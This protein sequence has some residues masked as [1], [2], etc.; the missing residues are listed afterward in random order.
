M[1][2][3]VQLLASIQPTG[4][5]PAYATWNVIPASYALTNGNRTAN[6]SGAASGVARSSTAFSGKQYHENT[7]TPAANGVGPGVCNAAQNTGASYLGQTSDGMGYYLPGAD[8]YRTG[9]VLFNGASDTTT[10]ATVGMATDATA[11]DLKVWIRRA[12]GGGWE[13]G[14][15]PTTGSTPTLTLPTGTYYA[16]C[17]CQTGT[18]MTI[19][20]GQAAFVMW[21]PSGGY[22]GY[23]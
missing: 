15:D 1:T 2:G 16:A 10:P 14:G 5:G 18:N 13:G 19:N 21:T 22:T 4:G 8:A 7:F 11:G 12:N 3:I 6:R 9:A 23:Y 20:A 17:T